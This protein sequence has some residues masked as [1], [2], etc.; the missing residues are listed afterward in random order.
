MAPPPDLPPHDL[1]E[2]GLVLDT[3]G[4]DVIEDDPYNTPEFRAALIKHFEKARNSALAVHA[5]DA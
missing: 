3:V 1:I 5:K 2:T 4:D